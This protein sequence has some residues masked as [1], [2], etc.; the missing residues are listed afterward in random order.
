VF[1]PISTTGSCVQVG[2]QVSGRRARYDQVD[3]FLLIRRAAVAANIQQA[4]YTVRQ[5]VST[6]TVHRVHLSA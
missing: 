5:N 6:P 3:V 2:R 4:K 1:L